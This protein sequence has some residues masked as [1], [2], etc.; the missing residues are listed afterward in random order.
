MANLFHFNI[1]NI[2]KG[3]HRFYKRA[4]NNGKLGKMKCINESIEFFNSDHNSFSPYSHIYLNGHLSSIGQL[5]KIVMFIKIS[6][7]EWCVM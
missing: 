2:G 6:F 3:S 1:N 4:K 7:L 5:K